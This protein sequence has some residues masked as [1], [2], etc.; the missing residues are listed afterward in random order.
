MSAHWNILRDKHMKCNGG[1]EQFHVTQNLWESLMACF[2]KFIPPL[3]LP[4]SFC[5]SQ[6]SLPD[7]LPLCHT[8]TLTPSLMHSLSDTLPH[9]HSLPDTLPHSHS[10]HSLTPTSSTWEKGGF[11]V[12]EM[13]IKWDRNISCVISSSFLVSRNM[14][15]PGGQKLAE[16]VRFLH[17]EIQTK[18][19]H[20]GRVPSL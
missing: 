1:L 7:A 17:S 14:T 20:L 10:T 5:H 13:T 6:H 8:P 18:H 4:N 15:I 2:S 11:P 3:F 19:E 16:C 9:S 12:Q